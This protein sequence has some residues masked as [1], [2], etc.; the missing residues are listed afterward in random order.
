MSSLLMDAPGPTHSLGRRP[1]VVAIDGPAGAGKSTA[2][3]R[4]T[5]L[6]GYRLLDTGALY[7]SVALLANRRGVAWDDEDALA[8]I[9][10]Q[11]EIEFRLE[12]MTNH[13]FLAGEDVTAA[14]RTP[15][16]S[17]GSSVVSALPRVRAALLGLQRRLASGGG[18]VVEGRD[19]GTVVFPSA[20]AKFFLTASD[21]VR[22]QRRQ[23]ELAAAGVEADLGETLTEMRRRDER[24][25]SR[26]VSPLMCAPDAVVLDS[27]ALTVDEVANRMLDV[28]R[29][30]E[31]K[32]V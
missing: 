10:G 16:V 31:A 20:P 21:E 19:I 17:Q 5:A 11:L 27:S 13:V 22:A 25:A 26:A 28:V 4:L 1:I 15:E 9:A 30:R 3:K 24:D 7:R 6:L 14:I 12:D 8:D 32:T 29:E 2:A 18:V 23:A